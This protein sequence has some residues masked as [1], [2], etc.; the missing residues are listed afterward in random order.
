MRERTQ[1]RE[2]VG[3]GVVMGMMIVLRRILRGDG[4]S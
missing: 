1:E 4:K 2:G 3:R